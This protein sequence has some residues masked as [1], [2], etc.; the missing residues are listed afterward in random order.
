MYACVARG[1]TFGA[2]A[3]VYAREKKK[4]MTTMDDPCCPLCGSPMLRIEEQYDDVCAR[5]ILDVSC[6]QCDTEFSVHYAYAY[7]DN[8]A[9]QQPYGPEYLTR[10]AQL[11][12]M[13]WEG[14]EGA[15]QEI[16]TN[17]AWYVVGYDPWMLLGG[18]G[19]K[20]GWV[21][22]TEDMPM[23]LAREDA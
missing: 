17:G 7:C 4:A 3:R 15:W 12:L 11:A 5:P 23:I 8:I 14:H 16:R 9:I 18:Y 1:G 13:A 22:C 21:T 20:E 19:R 6:R 2:H 10:D